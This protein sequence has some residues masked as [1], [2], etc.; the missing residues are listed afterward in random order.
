MRHIYSILRILIKQVSEQTALYS[1]HILLLKAAPL[2]MWNVYVF[3]AT[4][5]NMVITYDLQPYS[6]I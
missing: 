3:I 6:R 4:S 5:Q 2:E 1:K